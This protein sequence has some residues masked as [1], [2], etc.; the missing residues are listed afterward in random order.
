MVADLN[1]YLVFL[2]WLSRDWWTQKNENNFTKLNEILDFNPKELETLTLT[3]SN[4]NW[5]AN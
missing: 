2:Q 5:N 3:N 4:S 1:Y